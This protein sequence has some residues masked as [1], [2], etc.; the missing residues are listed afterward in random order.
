M[1]QRRGAANLI[2]EDT[3]RSGGA[4]AT[5]S[6]PAVDVGAETSAQSAIA[7]SMAIPVYNE[8]ESVGTLYERLVRGWSGW[9][10]RMRSSSWTT[11]ARTVPSRPCARCT[12]ATRTC[13]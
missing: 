7:I 1:N 8:V 5:A 2:P 9:D 12:S 13:A 4:G 11:A 3:V 10:R 6:M